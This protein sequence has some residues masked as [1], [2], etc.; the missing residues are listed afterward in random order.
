[1]DFARVTTWIFDLDNT[2]YPPGVGLFAQIERRMTAY[3][4]RELGLAEPEADRLRAQY[5]R[6]HGTTLAGLMAEHAIDPHPYLAEVHDIDFSALTPDA[7]LAAAI[8]A[9]PGRK[10]VHTNAD[11]A[12]AG[13][14]LARRGLGGF[15]AIYGIGE[16]DFHPKPD[17]R[18]YHAV[19]DAHGIDPT[20]AAFFEDDPR[21]LAVPHDLGMVTVLVG[22][23]GTAPP[24]PHIHHVTDNLTAFLAGLTLAPAHD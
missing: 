16:V 18:A 8:A 17:P 13:H 9:L 22:G 24:A 4:A 19:L 5:W 21:N 3:V 11:A 1:M 10:I 6:D 20:R 12:Y 14:V 2:L 23:G 7:A 15:E